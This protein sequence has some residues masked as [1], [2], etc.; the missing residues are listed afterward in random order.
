MAYLTVR[1]LSIQQFVIEMSKHFTLAV[2]TAT[3]AYNAKK[4]VN[5]VFI[6]NNVPLLFIWYNDKCIAETG[7]GSSDQP[8][9]KTAGPPAADFDIWKRNDQSQWGNHLDLD[10][11]QREGYDSGYFPRYPNFCPPHPNFRPPHPNF[12]P[13]PPLEPFPYHKTSNGGSSSYHHSDQSCI[14]IE[15]VKKSRKVVM[16]KPL[17][18]VWE[19]Y[20]EYSAL[21]TASDALCSTYCFLKSDLN[22]RLLYSFLDY[23]EHD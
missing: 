23:D 22:C 14:K 16:I 8:H 5:D 7:N 1:L 18:L 15:S 11:G 19:A 12:C 20:P 3:M 4:I 13:P 21:N 17:H 2:W 6:A 9:L 10:S